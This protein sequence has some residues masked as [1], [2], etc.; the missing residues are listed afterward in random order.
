MSGEGGT[1][2]VVLDEQT[3]LLVE[4]LVH[5]TIAA[6]A[7]D[8][9]VAHADAARDGAEPIAGRDAVANPPRSSGGGAGRV[10]AAIE[11]GDEGLLDIRCCALLTGQQPSLKNMHMTTYM[12]E[13]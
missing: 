5:S 4:N 1:P 10:S 2:P 7:T 11:P 13:C 3:R 8:D 6:R 9:T 12:I